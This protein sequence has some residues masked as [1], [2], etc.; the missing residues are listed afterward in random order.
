[1]CQGLRSSSKGL[2]KDF[3]INMLVNLSTPQM[4]TDKNTD[5]TSHLQNKINSTHSMNVEINSE[6]AHMSWPCHTP[7]AWQE[8]RR[9]EPA[10]SR[11]GAIST[12]V[13]EKLLRF[14]SP[15]PSS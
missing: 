7:Q 5:V 15:T 12:Q 3:P 11:E 10:S 8:R 9:L 4:V 6:T 1:M 13:S 14:P 2:A